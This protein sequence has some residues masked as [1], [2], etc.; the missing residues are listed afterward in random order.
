MIFRSIMAATLLFASVQLSGCC[1]SDYT[2]GCEH[3]G[4]VRQAVKN[5]AVACLGKNDEKP[6]EIWSVFY[7]DERNIF[8]SASERVC[9]SRYGNIIHGACENYFPMIGEGQILTGE[10]FG[11]TKTIEY[12]IDRMDIDIDSDKYRRKGN[13]NP[14]ES[15]VVSY[16]KMREPERHRM[17]RVTSCLN[18]A[19]ISLKNGVKNMLP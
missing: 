6:E 14:E 9:I 5:K 17:N 18:S 10:D 2:D 8:T 1:K 16:D 19:N 11:T 7:D 12:H 13:R 4:N 3:V 15:T